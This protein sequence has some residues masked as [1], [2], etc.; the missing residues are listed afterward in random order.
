MENRNNLW[1]LFFATGLLAIAV[2]QVICRD[3]RPLILPPGFP[4]WLPSR[5]I[6]DCIFSVLLAVAC[7]CIIFSIKARSVSLLLAVVLLLMVII[8]QLPGQQYPAHLGTWTNAFKELA[9]SGG[10]FLVATSLPRQGITSGL[11]AF[12]EKLIPLGKYFFAITMA[13]FGYMHFLY[14]DFVAPLVPNWIPGHLFWT[15]F[16]GVAL[17]AGGIGI[18]VNIKR[19]LAANLLGIVIFIWL[20]VLHFPRAI[21]DPHSGD[22][23]EWT[24]VFEALSFSGIAFLIANEK[25]LKDF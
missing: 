24:S 10:A 5:F 16:A 6:W 7:G 15:Y 22:G 13:V 4:A 1:R 21:A 20:I 9:Y 2:Q 23:N 12:F 11:I 14:P 18:I 3:F 17:M 8:F 19:R 25:T